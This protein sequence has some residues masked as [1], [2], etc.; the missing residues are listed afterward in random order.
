MIKFISEI[1]SK[2]QNNA[3]LEEA[4]IFATDTKELFIDV[5]NRR[6]QIN[7]LVVVDTVANLDNILAPLNKFYYVEENNLI[8]KYTKDGWKAIT[9]TQDQYTALVASVEDLQEKYERI[10][11]EVNIDY[12]LLASG[13]VNDTYT[14]NDPLF[15]TDTTVRL[16][17][18]SLTNNQYTALSA[19]KIIPDDTD[20]ANNNLILK[21]T[22]DVPNIDIPII[23][24]L[25]IPTS[26]LDTI[27]DSLTSTSRI[28]PLSANQGRVLNEKIGDL[29]SLET[30][31]KDNVVSAVNEIY[32][33]VT[34]EKATL[35]EIKAT[36]TS[37]NDAY[38]KITAENIIGHVLRASLWDGNKYSIVNSLFT[39]DVTIK[40]YSENLTD[41][42]YVAL[43]NAKI[44]TSDVQLDEN[45]IVLVADGE[46]PVIDI[47]IMISVSMPSAGQDQVIDILTSNST[48]SALSANMGRELK[49]QLGD[50]STLQTTNQSDIVGAVNELFQDVDNGKTLIASAITDKGINTSADATFDD[51]ATNIRSIESD[52]NAKLQELAN[53]VTTAATDVISGKKFINS[54]G[55]IEE[56]TMT[57]NQAEDVTLS[58]GEQYKIP[59]GHHNGSGTISVP[60]LSTLTPGTATA[61]KIMSGY[62]AVV[63]GV[64]VVGTFVP[65]NIYMGYEAPSDD[66][67][68]VGDIYLKL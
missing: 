54:T 26:S 10:T 48:T 6:I 61:D 17:A 41:S 14:I 21:A 38:Q 44:F 33:D 50:L 16:S 39:R 56:G 62:T 35:E 52:G 11:T 15:T 49:S 4:I 55:Q 25:F 51:M 47:P 67:G 36:T 31:N 63:D 12:T 65:N 29:N 5:N 9:T 59:E 40:I 32:Q 28:T 53:E 22:G 2:I 1:K 27:E 68:N 30:Q 8:Y 18:P 60:D 57:I 64:T 3:P 24:S 43:S 7:D 37:L 13:W 19:A 20:I 23:I 45:T 66:V 42:Q 46:I 34:Y 58:C